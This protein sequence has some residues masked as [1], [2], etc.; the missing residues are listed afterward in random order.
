MGGGPGSGQW[1]YTVGEPCGRRIG[2]ADLARRFHLWSADRGLP[3]RPRS[4]IAAA[5]R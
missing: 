1:I 4:E 2:A 3:D 5:D